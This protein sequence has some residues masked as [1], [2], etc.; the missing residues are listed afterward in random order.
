[1]ANGKLGSWN[2]SAGIN[3]AIYVC[4]KEQATVLTLN[5]VNRN[6]IPADVR[7]A[8]STS[9][10]DPGLAEYIEFDV[11]IAPKGVLE[12]TGLVV[13]PNQYLLVK[14]DVAQVNAVCW[15][16]E[17]GD[18]AYTNNIS[19]NSGTTPTWVTPAGSLGTVTVGSPTSSESLSL[20]AT[21]P[22]NSVLQFS[23]TSG[24]LPAG[25][26]L[27]SNGTLTNRKTTT[28]YTAGASGETTS[29]DIRASNGTNGVVRSFSITKK[30]LDGSTQALAAPSGYWLAENIGSVY[31]SS[32]TRWIKSASMPNALQMY[33]DMTEEGGGYDFYQ[34]TGGPSVSY[35]TE[36]HGGT[37][38]GLGLVMPRS[39]YHWRA[40]RNYVSNVIGSTDYSRFAA[41][42]GIYR[43]GPAVGPTSYVSFPMRSIHYAD[44]IG[45]RV[46]PGSWAPDWKVL[47]NGRWWLRD[48]VFTEPNGDHNL[49]GFLGDLAGRNGL[50]TGYNLQDIIFNDGGT[51]ATG[52]TYLVSTNAKP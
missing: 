12:R 41:V 44:K 9:A 39:K 52:A 43:D 18:T 31:I 13:G 28:G 4:N 24:S 40:M 15:G 7:V 20:A 3:Q 17:V 10:T 5:I 35:I 45:D 30:W 46:Q 42:P 14:S 19:P 34:I 49:N 2:L 48:T 8:I 23:V 50:P 21:D 38:L 37:A 25:M 51:Y 27:Q 29:F 36:A 33:V 26:D 1:M 11:E 47:D 16:I 6:N 22:Y 32:G